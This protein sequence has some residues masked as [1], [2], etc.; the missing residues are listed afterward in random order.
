VLIKSLALIGMMGSGKTSLAKYVGERL[1]VP[2]VDLDAAI[3]AEHQVQIAEV[4]ARDGE[5]R[6]RELE[7]CTLEA[8]TRDKPHPFILACGGGTPTR[9]QNRD[10]LRAFY[11]VVWLK[12]EPDSL[13]RRIQQDRTVR[14]LAQ[15]PE[16]FRE[17]CAAREP[18][19]AATAHAVIDTTGL[20]VSDVADR[21]LERWFHIA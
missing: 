17:L 8:M 5:E 20:T 3:E 11:F 18:L 16:R 10:L 13:Y 1:R 9:Q 15:A 12:A 14:P 4:F 7:T 19:Y 21:V 2:F 6:F